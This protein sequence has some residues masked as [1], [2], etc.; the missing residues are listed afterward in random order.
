[1]LRLHAL[2]APSKALGTWA[3]LIFVA[4]LAIALLAAPALLGTSNEPVPVADTAA[5][6]SDARAP[7]RDF[8][9]FPDHY[10]NQATAPAD[11]VPT[12]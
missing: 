9:Y 8:D 12:F 2:R 4:A 3:F 6:T 1:M 7:D 10:K 5:S 11:P